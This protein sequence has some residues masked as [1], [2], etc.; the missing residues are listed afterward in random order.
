MRRLLI[1][2]SQDSVVP[3]NPSVHPLSL[4]THTDSERSRKGV[5]GYQE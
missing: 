5:I 2:V 1:N 3:P 4:I